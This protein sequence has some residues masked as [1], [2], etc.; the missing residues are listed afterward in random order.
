MFLR[1][2]LK[3]LVYV[4]KP[5]STPPPSER[6]IYSFKSFFSW[7]WGIVAPHLKMVCQNFSLMPSLVVV[8]LPSLK[9]LNW[10][11]CLSPVICTCCVS[12]MDGLAKDVRGTSGC[13]PLCGNVATCK[14]AI[15]CLS[16]GLHFWEHC[17]LLPF[18]WFFFVVID[19]GGH[20]YVHLQFRWC[21]PWVTGHNG[22][23]RY[24]V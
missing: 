21:A 15:L 9:C 7:Q 20:R 2:H 12:A 24:T 14:I 5:Y 17:M 16:F 10:T 8:R 11:H 23:G 1:D 22:T 18:P 4:F 19:H 3:S 13:R 6:I